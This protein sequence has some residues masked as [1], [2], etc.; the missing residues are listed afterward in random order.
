MG[1]RSVPLAPSF[2]APPGGSVR[3][4]SNILE[5]GPARQGSCEALLPPLGPRRRWLALR[6]RRR[7]SAAAKGDHR[8][9]LAG[10]CRQTAA[11]AKVAAARRR[12]D[13]W[14]KNRKRREGRVIFDSSYAALSRIITIAGSGAGG[15]RYI[16]MPAAILFYDNRAPR[17]Q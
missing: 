8:L 7:G 6:R 16:V 9:V 4:G 15:R 14:Q 2:F 12:H 1:R 17:A 11:W 5:P 3:C 13:R 10:V